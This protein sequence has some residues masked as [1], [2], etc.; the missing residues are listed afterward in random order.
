MLTI[1]IV[2]NVTVGQTPIN[3]GDVWMTLTILGAI[4]LSILLS[5]LSLRLIAI[6]D[7]Q[8]SWHIVKS[9]DIVIHYS[10]HSITTAL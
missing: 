1:Q 7:K 8:V 5:S 10:C 4:A 6:Y 2:Y 3:Q 9:L